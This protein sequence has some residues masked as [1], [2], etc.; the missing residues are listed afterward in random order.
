MS[1]WGHQERLSRT[2]GKPV[3]DCVISPQDVPQGFG[4]TERLASARLVDAEDFL[5]T[6]GLW[7]PTRWEPVD[8]E[9][10]R[11]MVAEELARALAGRPVAGGAAPPMEDIE[12]KYGAKL[13]KML[14]GLAAGSPAESDG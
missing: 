10:M 2:D 5:C 9:E 8:I 7:Q 4:L 6:A 1:P 11:R 13:D 12:G 3:R 14:G